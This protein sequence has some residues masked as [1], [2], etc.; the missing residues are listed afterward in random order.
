MT[1]QKIA[2]D[3]ATDINKQKK[4]ELETLKT[5]IKY[6]KG[7]IDRNIDTTTNTKTL[8]ILE[9]ELTQK[10][11]DKIEGERIRAKQDKILLDERPTS[12]F[13][14]KEKT[15]GQSKQ[16]TILKTDGNKDLEP[17]KEILME[18]HKFYSRLYDTNHDCVSS[19]G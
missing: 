9:Q 11:K 4:H 2:K 15:K 7:K 19:R 10:T 6:I 16:I 14:N 3:R 8:K 17:K 5:D 13:Y 12:Y 18:I 1:I